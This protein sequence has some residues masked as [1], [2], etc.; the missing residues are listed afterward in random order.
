MDT[1]RSLQALGASVFTLG[2]KLMVLTT[3]EF[4]D[5]KAGEFNLL[6]VWFLDQFARMIALQTLEPGAITKAAETLEFDVRYYHAFPRKSGTESEQ[7][8]Q[9]RNLLASLV[10]RG[11]TG[12]EEFL[13]EVR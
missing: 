10:M 2:Q 8:Q 9:I 5:R 11:S 12:R 4:E 7:I 3:D 13:Q 1:Q 6:D